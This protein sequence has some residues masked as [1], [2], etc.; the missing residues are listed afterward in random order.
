[1]LPALIRRFHEAAASGA[2][3]VVLWG[4]GT[5][6]REFLHVDDLGRAIVR[7]LDVYDDPQ[8]INVGVGEDVTIRELAEIV[9]DV[10]DFKGEI[11]QDASRPDGTPRKLLDVSRIRALGWAPTIPLREGIEST[12]RWFVDHED[13]V[14]L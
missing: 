5:P 8:T 13:E 1:V 7:L 2:E 12:Y 11:V 14:R 4:S 3:R 6:R 10:V 9:A